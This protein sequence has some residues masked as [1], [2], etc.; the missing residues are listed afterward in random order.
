MN[1]KRLFLE[2]I[3]KITKTLFEHEVVKDLINDFN[4]GEIK[5]FL[6]KHDNQVFAEKIKNASLSNLTQLELMSDSNGQEVYPSIKGILREIEFASDNYTEIFDTKDE[7]LVVLCK[8]N[9]VSSLF[10]CSVTFE[11]PLEDYDEFAKALYDLNFR[12]F[13]RG[14]CNSKFGL[15]PS[16][17]RFLNI[18]DDVI[19]Y[20]TI[21]NKYKEH[22]FYQ[23]YKNVFPK[24]DNKFKMMAYIQHCA[25]YSPL[26]DISKSLDIATI[27]ACSGKDINP[28]LYATI[29]SAVFA[30][31][32]KQESHKKKAKLNI[33]W[34]AEKIEFYTVI[35]TLLSGEKFLFECS[36]KDFSVSYSLI[37]DM[38]NDRMKYQQGAFLFIE[39]GFIV[40]GHLLIP[41]QQIDIV[42]VT[43]PAKMK[44]ELYTKLVNKTSFYDIDSLYNPYQYISD[45][46]KKIE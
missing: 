5:D 38:T 42:K 37:S 40:N 23:R 30:F 22:G 2:S 7:E 12:F 35:K 29:D 20:Q 43:I 46:S 32:I 21:E 8:F 11:F 39:D 14:Q 28:N 36:A 33:K 9:C 6:N 31:R 41:N 26:L 13:Y 25:S 3:S 44:K 15:L 24:N 34:F 16:F 19:T 18:N 4:D 1:Q 45:Y 27:F 10:L 17:Y